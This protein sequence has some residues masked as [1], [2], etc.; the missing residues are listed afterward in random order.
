[1]TRAAIPQETAIGRIAIT[2]IDGGA[3]ISGIRIHWQFNRRILQCPTA[4]LCGTNWGRFVLGLNR[5]SKGANRT[6][7]QWKIRPF[8]APLP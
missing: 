6:T 3:G 8:L 4:I 1:M 7:V 5:A 2:E